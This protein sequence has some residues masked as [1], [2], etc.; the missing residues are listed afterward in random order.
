VEFPK[1]QLVRSGQVDTELDIDTGFHA[2]AAFVV[3]NFKRKRLALYARYQQRHGILGGHPRRT[4][5]V[6]AFLNIKHNG[7]AELSGGV[8]NLEVDPGMVIQLSFPGS[9]EWR[10]RVDH[11]RGLH[12]GKRHGAR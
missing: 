9:G 2:D 10:V 1:T 8:I 6:T 7:A 12:D 5:T 4:T 3:L 11:G